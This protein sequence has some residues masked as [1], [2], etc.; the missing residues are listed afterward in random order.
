MTGRRSPGKK[1]W[2]I[3]IFHWAL[4]DKPMEIAWQYLEYDCNPDIILGRRFYWE[5]YDERDNTH[6]TT[7]YQKYFAGEADQTHMT[8]KRNPGRSP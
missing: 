6:L 1:A 7:A 8:S 5:Q 3:D 4:A 2:P